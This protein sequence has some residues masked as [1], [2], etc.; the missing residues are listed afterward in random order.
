VVSLVKRSSLDQPVPDLYLFGL[1]GAFKGYYPGYAR[2]ILTSGD[3]FTWAVLKAHTGNTAGRVTLRSRDPREMPA[4]NFHYFEEGN[5]KEEDLNAVVEGIETVR[6]INARSGD[7]IEEEILP[8]PGVKTKAQIREFIKD[9][10]WGHHAS[11]SCRIG[12]PGDKMAVVD[13]RFKVHGI[14]NL[15]VVDA[16]VFPRIPGFFIVCAIYMIGE[17]ARDVIVEDAHKINLDPDGHL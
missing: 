15:R 17:K 9:N 11:C 16:S 6:R 2:S 12:P 7:A 8:G 1:L 10:A 3:H 13:S 5:N 4:I 14:R